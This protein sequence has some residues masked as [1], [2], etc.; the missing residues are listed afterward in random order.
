MINGIRFKVCGLTSLLDAETVEACGADYLGFNFYEKSPR[1]ISLESFRAMAPHL[2]RKPKIAVTVEPT[3]E[4]VIRL[5]DDGFDF[6]QFHFPHATPLARVEAWAAAVTPEKLWL[7]PR[8]PPGEAIEPALFSL[9]GT[10]LFDTYQAGT[11][12]GTGRAGDWPAFSRLQD[13]HPRV[14]WILAGGLT[15]ENIAAALTATHARQ[16][17][18]NSGIESVPGI[19]SAEKLQ[20]FC[21]ALRDFSSRSRPPIPGTA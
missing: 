17:D 6:F 13:E 2:P 7:A 16:V 15:A 3:A 20:R 11:Y 4:E 5:K 10:F 8:V 21:T 19:K 12:G 9:A 18:V 1:Y 14:N